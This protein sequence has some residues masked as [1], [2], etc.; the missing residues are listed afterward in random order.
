MTHRQML[1]TQVV[2]ALAALCFVGAA[3]GAA[4]V[5]NGMALGFALWLF[6]KVAA[7]NGS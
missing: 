2:W 4:P 1:V 6:G 7:I 3:F 5:W